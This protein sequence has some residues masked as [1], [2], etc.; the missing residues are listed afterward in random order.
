MRRV[1]QEVRGPTWP[2]DLTSAVK[3]GGFG[4]ADSHHMKT[5]ATGSGLGNQVPAAAGAISNLELQM[6]AHTAIKPAR[7][8]IGDVDL[9]QIFYK[10]EPVATF[11]QIDRAHKR[12]DGTAKRNFDE[13]RE[14][15]LS[16]QDFV[17]LNR[18]E[19]RTDLGEGVFSKFAPRG[20]LITRRGYLKIAKSLTDDLAWSVFDDMVERYFAVERRSVITAGVAVKDAV[21][22]FSAYKRFGRMIGLDKNQALIAANQAT[23][24]RTGQNML[25]DVGVTHLTAPEQVSILT[26]SE[27]GERL[28]GLS[29]KRVNQEIAALGLQVAVQMPKGGKAWEPTPAGAPYAKW[30]DTGKRH[31]DGVPVRQ[32]KWLSTLLGLLRKEAA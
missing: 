13:N 9:E 7:V 25:A 10:G 3:E 8:Q 22:V 18:D 30:L 19:I 11:A 2:F 6:H 15:F 28:G 4:S 17:E 29:G 23:L 31:G 20:H 1:N 12:P 26:P 27:I 24:K 16:G 14:R 32:L 5:A 21:T